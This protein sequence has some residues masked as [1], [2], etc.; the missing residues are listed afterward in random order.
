MSFS[1]YL[2]TQVLGHVFGSTTLAKPTVYI[3]LFTT[4]PTDAGGGTEVSTAGTAYARQLLGA[5]TVTSGDP[6]TVR[7][8]ANIVFPVATGNY[9]TVV[10]YGA[11]DA[12]TGGN[13]LDW[14]PLAS[15]KT[16]TT[17]DQFQILTNNL[18]IS[19]D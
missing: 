11:Y 6:T 4:A 3:A 10:A 2:E 8:N 9:G 5:T 18:T 12:L 17:G 19:L 15:S 7:N 13:L 1:N 16:V 14:A